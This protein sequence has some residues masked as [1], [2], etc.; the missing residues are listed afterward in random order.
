MSTRPNLIFASGV[1]FTIG[2][3]SCVP[4]YLEAA[5]ATSTPLLQELGFASLATIFVGLLVTWTGFI[6]RDRWAWFVMAIIVWVWA[7][8]AFVLPFLQPYTPNLLTERVFDAW[9][10]RGPQRGSTIG[11]LIFAVLATAL[12]LPVKSFFW[13]NESRKRTP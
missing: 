10:H 6:R 4:S 3:V 2:L 13:T 8:P 12:I 11:G 5:G 7:F 1:L 9:M